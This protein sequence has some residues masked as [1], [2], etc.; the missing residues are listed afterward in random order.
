MD[1]LNINIYPT[2]L[3]INKQDLITKGVNDY[4]KLSFALHKEV[5]KKF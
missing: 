4:E 5:M 3:I 1:E 2:H